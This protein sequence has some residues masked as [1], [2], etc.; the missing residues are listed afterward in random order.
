MWRSGEGAGKKVDE[1]KEVWV[2]VEERMG[3]GV[4]RSR[5]SQHILYRINTPTIPLLTMRTQ[6]RLTD[7]RRASVAF[8]PVL[9][10][11]SLR[12]LFDV[13]GQSPLEDTSL[14]L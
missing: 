8:L 4:S 1:G 7:E 12:G 3:L 13:H 11:F 2:R 5:L 6:T 14:V 10:G 9:M